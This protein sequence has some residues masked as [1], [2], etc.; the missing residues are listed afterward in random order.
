MK[1]LPIAPL[2]DYD[3]RLLL[4]AERVI[5]VVVKLNLMRNRGGKVRHQGASSETK[6]LVTVIKGH[7]LGGAAWC[8]FAGGG[9]V[10]V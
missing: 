6:K 1:Q 8:R 9:R 7:R 4:C 2:F 5:K 3:E 10:L